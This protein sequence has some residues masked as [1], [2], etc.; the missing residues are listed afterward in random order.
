MNNGLRQIL[1]NE[2]F[3]VV[4]KKVVFIVDQLNWKSELKNFITGLIKTKVMSRHLNSDTMPQTDRH[5]VE[6][7]HQQMHFFILKS[8][9]KFTLKY[10]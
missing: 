10:T 9:L 8:T 7:T 3:F 5:D 6:F 2:I 4:F 1:H